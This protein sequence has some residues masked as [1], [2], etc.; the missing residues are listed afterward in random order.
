MQDSIPKKVRL[1]GAYVASGV[2]LCLGI[3]GLLV[4]FSEAKNFIT[5]TYGCGL[6]VLLIASGTLIG[7]AAWKQ[8]GH[9]LS[10][11]AGGILVFLG[12]LGLLIEFHKAS[13]S[14]TN[15]YGYVLGVVLIVSGALTCVAVRLNYGGGLWSFFGNLFVAAAIARVALAWQ[16][17]MQGRHFISPIVVH[18]I[19]AGLWGVGCYCLAWGHMRH[20]RKKAMPPNLALD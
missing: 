5:D 16:V 4:E 12:A 10:Y 1:V 6:A 3:I 7:L 18:S 2:L 17:Y 8:T 11:A 9:V 19:T 15:F 14:S 20:H 13:P